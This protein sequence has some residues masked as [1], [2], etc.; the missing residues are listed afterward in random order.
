MR[1]I[2]V[3]GL[4][5]VGLVLA[6]CLAEAG[7]RVFGVDDNTRLVEDM[8]Q[9][10]LHSEEPGVEE[11][12]K[13]SLGRSLMV[14]DNTEEAVFASD[15]SFLVV[16][17]PSNQLGGFSLRYVKQACTRIGTALQKKKD[18]HIIAVVS[19]ML[20]GSS[21]YI[22]IPLLEQVSGRKIGE[23]LGYA[24]NP[25]FIALGEVI[26]GF[27]EPDYILIGESD[28]RAG[29]EILAIQRTIVRNDASAVRLRPIEAEIA[30]VASNT[31]DSMRVSFVNMLLSIC[32]ETPGANVDNITRGLAHRFGK[33]YF[34]GALPYG[35]PC[36]PRDN[37]A[38][39][40]FMQT[41]GVSNI[42]PQAIDSFNQEHGRYVLNKI[43]K[44]SSTRK[45]SFG[46][47]GLAYKLGTGVIERSF[48]LDLAGWLADGRRQVV[49]WDPLAIPG[50]RPVLGDRVSYANSAE[51]C[52]QQAEVIVIL[53]P[54]KELEY[55]D[56]S[57]AE[58][59]TVI[60][61]WRCLKSEQ[62]S[63]IENY[64]PLG[65]GAKMGNEGLPVK[66]DLERLRLLTD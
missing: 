51:E 46:L 29:D 36:W 59:R 5:K 27:R 10:R 9:G 44:I 45:Q 60:D 54:L 50:A 41:L 30:K 49:V 47:L 28:Q 56:W 11:D 43:L 40:V 2:S 23:T 4:G 66:L 62:A 42:L 33:R 48:A 12:L 24:Y 25:A 39:G 3:F 1:S 64:W 17:T 20:P 26:K 16:P 6:V 21:E 57:K 15:I 35:G 58:T 65:Q 34:K 61:C 52:I 14:A 55:I 31:H 63:Q 7:H 22:V 32:A 13:E 53:N 38:L 19:T 8:N 37:I 18:Y